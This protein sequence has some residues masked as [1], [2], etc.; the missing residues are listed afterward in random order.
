M[1]VRGFS[2]PELLVTIAVIGIL[3]AIAIPQLGGLLPWAKVGVGGNGMA[4]LNRAVLHY[5]QTAQAVDVAAA[6]GT[7]DELAVLTLLK[8]RDVALPGSPYVP[9]EFATDVSSETDVVRLQWNGKFFKMVPVGT[10]G[11]G[12]VVA[13]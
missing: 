2:L 10:A 9:A 8:T 12:I 1:K 4:L 5:G 13:R 7:A 3:A 6:S 11:A